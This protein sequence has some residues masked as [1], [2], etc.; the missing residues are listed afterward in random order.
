MVDYGSESDIKLVL[1][2]IYDCRY[3][4]IMAPLVNRVG[5]RCGDGG[6]R[7]PRDIGSIGGILVAELFRA[8]S[9]DWRDR[10]FQLVN[11]DMHA[12]T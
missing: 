5:L 9:S 10:T 12:H 1:I 7:L 4:V 11:V 6:M 8:G 2:S 3:E